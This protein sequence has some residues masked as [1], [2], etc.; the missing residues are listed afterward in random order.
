MDIKKFIISFGAGII[1]CMLVVYF[2]FDY[3]SL[4]LIGGIVTGIAIFA[5]IMSM[6]IKK[7]K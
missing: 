4:S 7:G 1:A 6:L 2:I 3:F 5:L